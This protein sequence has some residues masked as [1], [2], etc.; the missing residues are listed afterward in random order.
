MFAP[1]FAMDPS[2]KSPDYF[3][4]HPYAIS[5]KIKDLLLDAF[6]KD[7]KVSYVLLEFQRRWGSESEDKVRELLEHIA[8]SLGWKMS[9]LVKSRAI[10]AACNPIDF[11]WQ[12]IL[13]LESQVN[14]FV[15]VVNV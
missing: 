15:K 2:P 9:D 6:M 1:A 4:K 5:K 7:P 10:S 3:V 11:V 12:K 14:K 8:D 13:G